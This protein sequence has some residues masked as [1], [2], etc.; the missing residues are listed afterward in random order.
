MLEAGVVVGTCG[1]HAAP[2]DG[3]TIELGWGL[4]ASARGRGVGTTAVAGLLDA[5]RRRYPRAQIVAH[6]EWREDRGQMVADSEASEAIL[7]RLGFLAEDPPAEP[8]YRAWRL[9]AG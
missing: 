3:G 4:V 6:T 9:S 8:G 2:Q 1:T 7:R 5:T